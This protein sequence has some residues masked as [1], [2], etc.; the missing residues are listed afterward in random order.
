[1][2][3]FQALYGRQPPQLAELLL[4][5]EDATATLTPNASAEEIAI[6]IKQNLQQAQ[7]RMKS[8]ADKHRQE[9]TLEVG[10]MVYLKLQPYRH[11][12]LSLHKCLKLHSKY[13]GPFRVLAKVGHTSYKLL[14]P[15]GCQLHHTFHVS[16]LKKHL[17]PKAIPSPNLPLLNPDGTILIAPEAVLER[18]LIPRVQGSIS[19][20]VVQWLV[21][22]QNLPPE[23]ATWE[24]AS[25]I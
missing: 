9:R 16:Q 1:M 21:K 2:T 17:G 13:Y 14:L 22:W 10:D 3:P 24:D 18:K 8:Q 4:P 6:R 7:D 23:Q 20:P 15:D 11:T 12:S 19:I 5:P 25:F